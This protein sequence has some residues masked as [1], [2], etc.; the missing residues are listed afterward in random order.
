MQWV[1]WHQSDYLSDTIQLAES[2]MSA[3][4]S[5]RNM[6]S[7]IPIS[8]GGTWLSG[9]GLP[10][11]RQQAAL[12]RGQRLLSA[13]AQYVTSPKFSYIPSYQSVLLSHFQDVTVDPQRTRTTVGLGRIGRAAESWGTS[14]QTVPKLMWVR[15][16]ESL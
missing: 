4:A 11:R 6:N 16:S 12:L 3:F 14:G 7:I 13:H 9:S 10:S 5:P 2:L 1:Q 8:I 15:F